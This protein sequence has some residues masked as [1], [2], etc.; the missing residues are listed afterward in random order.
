[1][2]CVSV[3]VARAD[4]Q[5][6]MLACI[7]CAD[8]HRACARLQSGC[9]ALHVPQHASKR[10][11]R[12][13]RVDV[14]ACIRHVHESTWRIQTCRAICWLAYGREDLHR[15]VHACRAVVLLCMC[16]GRK[17]KARA[18]LQEWMCWLAFATF[19]RNV[20]R[21]DLQ[22]DVLDCMRRV[23]ACKTTCTR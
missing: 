10:H 9:A 22:S 18:P 21:G 16:R 20:A 11:V 3:H 5:S 8:L 2:R 6:D 17:Q 19:R 15:A 1:M 4:L 14:L 12:P 23:H 13:C 7:R